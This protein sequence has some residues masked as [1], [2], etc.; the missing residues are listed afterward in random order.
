M[1]SENP[2]RVSLKLKEGKSPHLYLVQLQE[3]MKEDTSLH[4]MMKRTLLMLKKTR[5]PFI[6]LANMR[7]MVID[8]TNSRHFD[9]S[10]NP[11]GD[12]VCTLWSE[13]EIKQHRENPKEHIKA[14]LNLFEKLGYEIYDYQTCSLEY[15]KMLEEITLKQ[16]EDQIKGRETKE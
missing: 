1:E 16:I 6:L 5:T 15:I 9:R 10:A 12:W 3:L 14:I 4:P 11:K 7:E 13:S 2:F 8:P